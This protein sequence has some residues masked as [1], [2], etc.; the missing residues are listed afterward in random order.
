MPRCRRSQGL[1]ERTL[2]AL[3]ALTTE[4]LRTATRAAELGIA[5]WTGATE[6]YVRARGGGSQSAH[7]AADSISA[8]SVKGGDT[9]SVVEGGAGGGAKG[10][11]TTLGGEAAD[12]HDAERI[13]LVRRRVLV[14]KHLHK[15][16]AMSAANGHLLVLLQT[17]LTRHRPPR[18]GSASS[19]STLVTQAAA[20][21]AA[22]AAASSLTAASG[23]SEATA[24]TPETSPSAPAAYAADTA[25]GANEAP[26][27]PAQAER[28]FV[29]GDALERS[30]FYPAEFGAIRAQLGELAAASREFETEQRAAIA[31]E[32]WPPPPAALR[33]RVVIDGS[34][35]C[36]VCAN[37]FSRQW[38][39]RG[40]CW[41][42]EATV[43]A[44]G[45]CPFDVRARLAA[46]AN[47]AGNRGSG[48]APMHFGVT[49]C[50]HQGKC[51]VCDGGFAPCSQCRLAHGDGETV[52]AICSEWQ[53]GK[54][55][56]TLMC[57]FDRS[58]CSTKAGGSPLQG[59]HSVDV[60]L[61]NL[62]S[63]YT[64]HVVTRNSHK[65]EISTFLAARA[66]P[67]KSVACVPK[68]E[69][70]AA[71]MRELMPGLEH[72]LEQSGRE[73]G[74]EHTGG[75]EPAP[76]RAVFVDDGVRECCDE[77]VAAL[78]GVY[79]VLFRRGT[80]V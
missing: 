22:A 42:C 46:S 41:Q 1:Q 36:A 3:A 12:G 33:T 58:L 15:L 29:A 5:D 68:G 35:T 38:I 54:V 64:M 43:R 23:H 70:K 2:A 57:D 47:G 8:P 78:P 32:G 62:A 11:A 77:S 80:V 66:V 79:R 20:R 50:P 28:L 18:G 75:A 71:A 26:A 48:R 45:V 9:E 53:C 74:T 73:H 27:A 34:V 69:S 40:V 39:A 44:S 24:A 51:V 63:Q 60:E 14:S 67:V 61:A 25:H 10:S 21:A 59:T 56:P 6:A 76:V 16:S 65:D 4:Q 19:S 7:T 31:R 55:K 49:F 52:A 72:G 17:L 30:M 37:A 13:W